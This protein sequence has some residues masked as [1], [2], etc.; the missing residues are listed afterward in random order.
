MVRTLKEN[1]KIPVTC[2]IRCLDTEEKT[3]DLA[4][5]IEEAGASV[6]TV[7][8]RTKEHKKSYAGPVNFNI[9]KKIK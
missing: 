7:H 8:G 5:K 2:K 3:I 6:L 4:R 9:I 1:L